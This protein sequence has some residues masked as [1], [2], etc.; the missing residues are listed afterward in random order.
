MELEEF[1]KR[2][3]EF[4]KN[5]QDSPISAEE[6]SS[7]SG[8][9]YFPENPDLRLLVPLTHAPEEEFEFETSSGERKSFKRIGK[10]GFSVEGQAAELTLYQAASGSFFLPFR[11]LTSG[12]ETYGAGRYVEIKKI[13]ENFELD[14]NYAYNPY[15]AYN[16]GYSCPL[17]P[18]ENWLKVPITAG[19]MNY[20]G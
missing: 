19:E 4:L 7:F 9:K 6:R 15:C 12:K 20:H 11:D 13:G 18:L 5:G 8:L 17:P 2:K 10:L 3:D 16:S 14:F 1:R